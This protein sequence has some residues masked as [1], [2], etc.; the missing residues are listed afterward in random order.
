VQEDPARGG[1]RL[2][3]AE[4]RDL[5]R[6]TLQ[7]IDGEF[8]GI[9]PGLPTAAKPPRRS[10]APVIVKAVDSTFLVVVTRSAEDTIRIRQRFRDVRMG[11]AEL[12]L[13]TD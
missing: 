5:A 11:N 9:K 4:L 10:V 6:K 8:I 7:V 13:G 1:V 2:T 3:A 12:E